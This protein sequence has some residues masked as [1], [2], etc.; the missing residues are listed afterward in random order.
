MDFRYLTFCRPGE[1]FYDVQALGGAED[2]FPAARVPLPEGW[3]RGA[4]EDWVIFRPPGAELPE[5][6][7]KIHVTA[8]PENAERISRLVRDYCL[9]HGVYFKFLR[10]AAV[11]VRRSG[12]YGDRGSSG[13]F[14]T[15]YSLDEE[16]LTRL[17]DDLDDLLT[18]E[19]GPYILSDLRWRS[20]PLYVRYGGFVAHLVRGPSGELVHCIK[21]PSGNWVPD[22]R[23]PGFRPPAWVTLPDRLQEALEAR[24]SAALTDFPYRPVKALHFSNGGGVYLATDTRTDAT[25][26]LK[27][28]RPLAGLDAA[29][30]DAV[31]RLR[32][33]YWAIRRLA[34]LDCMPAHA[35]FRKGHEHYYLVR[36][37]VEG[38]ALGQEMQERNPLLAAEPATPEDYAAYARWALDTL[39]RV[40]HGVRDLHARGVVF[41]DLH[42]NNVLLRPDGGVVFI[43]L[44]A[45]SEVVAAAPQAMA[46]PGYQ[47]PAGYTGVDVDRYAM[48]CL[49]LGVFLPLTQVLP[50]S[51][52]KA[53][54]FLSL[55]ADVFPVPED[56]A[57]R[58]RD[59]LAPPAGHAPQGDAAAASVTGGAEARAVVSGTAEAPV[60]PRPAADP[61]TADAFGDTSSWPVAGPDAEG[62]P[63]LRQRLADG[64]LAAASPERS[65][66]LYPGDIEQFHGSG[67]GANLAFGAA[68]VVWA[69]SQA[70]VEVPAD[71]VDWLVRAGERVEDPGFYDGLCGIAFAL[72][73]LGLRR[74]AAELLERAAARWT[75]SDADL[76]DSL[77]RGRA[78]IGLTLLHFAE[79][80]GEPDGIERAVRLANRITGFAQGGRRRHGLLHGG[81]G[82]ALFLCRLFAHTDEPKYLD[83]AV[84]ALRTDLAESGWA[85]DPTAR[86]PHAAWSVPVINGGA[87]LALVVDAVLAHR[88]DP[89]LALARTTLGERLAAPFFSHSGVF[90]GRAGAMLAQHR[91][92]TADVSG[93]PSASAADVPSALP[94][95]LAALGL[96]AAPHAGAP[97]FLGDQCLRLSTDFA[98]GT[99][100]VLLT[101]ET[102]LTGK[103]T[104]LPFLTGRVSRATGQESRIAA[105]GVPA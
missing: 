61:A 58:V 35:E 18:G 48:G 46:A 4:N 102:V 50:W 72:D 65:D 31:A 15:L 77:F 85:A 10:S 29:G 11:L 92:G 87:G 9:E 45:S 83:Q 79:K 84:E 99:A 55:I 21:D 42:P 5:Q 96:H 22:V 30:S 33:E 52:E 80:Y 3:T 32:N 16:M 74:P 63:E 64:I 56:F 47:A 104:G 70:G 60:S 19:T 51:S 105:E 2:D 59:D 12:K 97:A 66:R 100:G 62:W 90:T 69:L 71:H 89:E 1:V 76:D 68:G 24:N 75:A 53:E 78:G 82:Q 8:T 57:E 20:G 88:E 34:G 14:V 7:W 43:D 41:G 81:S 17:L 36:E 6:G 91:L 23:G 67:G 38:K 27:E 94:S 25:V 26:L 40:E 98:T 49:R 101:V 86:T 73:S 28:A 44:E 103:D 93:A 39:D 54:Q 37:Y 95:H 13:K